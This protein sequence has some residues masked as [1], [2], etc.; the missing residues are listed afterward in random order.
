MW[1]YMQVVSYKFNCVFRKSNIIQ[2][3]RMQILYVRAFNQN[4][5]RNNDHLIS[6]I[7]AI[8]GNGTGIAL[9]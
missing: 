8:P 6:R 2:S 3:K 4:I 7:N 5:G 1:N 9:P